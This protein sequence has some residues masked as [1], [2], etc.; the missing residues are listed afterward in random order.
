MEITMK[1]GWSLALAAL[2]VSPVAMAAE[3]GSQ[4]ASGIYRSVDEN[5]NVIFTDQKPE[6]G[7]AEEVQL[8]EL[9]TVPAEKVG[10]V[11]DA[12]QDEED[13][14]DEGYTRLVITSPANEATVRNPQA[15]VQV[16]VELEPALQPGDSLV[17]V[18]NGVEQPGMQLEDPVRGVHTLVVKVVGKDGE[19]KM[20]SEAVEFYIH[21]STVSD[22]RQRPDGNGAAADIGGAADTGGPAN[23][24]GGASTGGAAT[25]GGAA[26]RAK[27]ARPALPRPTPRN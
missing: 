3:A 27:P 24:G 23:V 7:D 10:N 9:N 1:I 26:D 20:T 18:D 8:R 21:R 14:E 5:G 2:M 4:S 11:L 12:G 25:V 16:A 22:F 19:V 17:L 6:N 13:A 15:A